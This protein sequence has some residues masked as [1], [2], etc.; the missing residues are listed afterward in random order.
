MQF[1]KILS[2]INVYII[3]IRSGKYDQYET[4]VPSISKP[5][6]IKRV[7]SYESKSNNNNF[8]PSKSS[9]PN[10]FMIKLYQRMNHFNNS[11]NF[12]QK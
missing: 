3:M 12:S 7:D 2:D 6:P 1:K 5:I 4:D 10:E 9:P 11:S 8:D